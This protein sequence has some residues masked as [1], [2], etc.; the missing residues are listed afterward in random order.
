MERGGGGLDSSDSKLRGKDIE[1]PSKKRGQWIE[2]EDITFD[3]ALGQ[4]EREDLEPRSGLA[5]QLKSR[6]THHQRLEN[7]APSHRI[8]RIGGHATS[9]EK[10]CKVKHLSWILKAVVVAITLY[11]LREAYHPARV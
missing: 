9:N 8:S 5:T 7:I 10:P 2:V 11:F 6:E 3:H 1:T 4:T